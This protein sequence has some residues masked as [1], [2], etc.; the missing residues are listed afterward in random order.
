MVRIHY[1]PPIELRFTPI[2]RWAERFFCFMGF[3]AQNG[4]EHHKTEQDSERI[5]QKCSPTLKFIGKIGVNNNSRYGSYL[6]C[7]HGKEPS[8]SKDGR[9]EQKATTPFC[10]PYRGLQYPSRPHRKALAV[11]LTRCRLTIKSPRLH[12]AYPAIRSQG[13]KETLPRKARDARH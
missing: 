9:R 6:S 3:A 7:A 8:P 4:A 1:S 11:I 2:K 13:S 10:H 5:S 12:V